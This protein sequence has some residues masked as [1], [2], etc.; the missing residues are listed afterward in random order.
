MGIIPARKSSKGIHNKNIKPLLSKPLIVY[1]IEAALKSKVFD[2]I[3]VSTDSFKIKKVSQKY[4]AEVPFLR[5]K[6]LAGDNTPMISVLRHAL[7]FLE[8]KE[9]FYP[10]VVVLLQPTS[11]LRKP[12]HIKKALEKF[13]KS[14]A[15]SVVTICEAEFSPYWMKRLL[16]DRVIPFIE[17]KKRVYTRRQDLPKVYRLNGAIYIAKRNIIMEENSILGED[18]R[19]IIMN[20]EDSIDIDTEIDFKLAELILKKRLCK[21]KR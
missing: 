4:G 21:S 20:Q 15:D 3:V 14:K 13:L 12:I 9:R 1:T 7:K 18:T 17:N 5:P 10:D 8:Q 2:R 6:N 16:K 19:A 11:P